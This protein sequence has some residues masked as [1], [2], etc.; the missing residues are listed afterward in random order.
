MEITTAVLFL[1]VYAAVR[2]ALPLFTLLAVSSWV[3]QRNT[4]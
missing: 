2:F 1:I 4:A 3:N